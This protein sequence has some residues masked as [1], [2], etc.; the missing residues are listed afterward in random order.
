MARTHQ[1]IW[2]QSDSQ[3]NARTTHEWRLNGLYQL[4]LINI[5]VNGVGF[6]NELE[7][8]VPS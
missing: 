8:L 4:K 1:R 2:L 6:G 3:H 5:N 7:S